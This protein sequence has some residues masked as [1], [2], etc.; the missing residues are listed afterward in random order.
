MCAA[1][2]VMQS[3][4]SDNHASL[5]LA[6]VEI[7]L[8]SGYVD[9]VRQCG[10]SL[11]FGMRF[12]VET[13]TWR[14]RKEG[15]ME[16]KM[17]RENGES[18][19]QRMVRLCLPL[20]NSINSDLEFTAEVAGEFD[21]N[22]LPTLDFEMWMEN[23]GTINHSYFQKPMK[24]NLVTMKRSAMSRHQKMSILSNEAVRRCQTSTSPKWT[25]RRCAS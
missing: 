22:R 9:D 23:N 19:D 6:K 10:T 17:L 25:G 5:E 8:L 1:R 7:T 11:R 24:T 2:L 3:W 12:M 21:N 20:A 13:M 16:D 18:R 15:A 4:G 14:W